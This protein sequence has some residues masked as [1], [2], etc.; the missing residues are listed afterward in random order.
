MNYLLFREALLPFRVISL[1]DIRKQFPDFDSRRLVEWQKK[2]YITRIT[3]KWYV[4]NETPRDELLLYRI[5]NCISYPSYVS[6]ETAMSYYGMIPEA[7]FSFQG[8]TTQ[9]TKTCETTVGT[10]IFKHVKHSLYFGYTIL[11]FDNIPVMI[12]DKEKALIDFCYLHPEIRTEND[13]EELRLNQDRLS[14]I[15]WDKMYMYLAV[16]N[17]KA[18]NKRIQ[19][20]KE[21][22]HADT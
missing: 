2:G 11:H 9:K 17:N 7:V 12:A 6:L 15:D 1:S 20:L 19:T 10:F 13:F 5:S 18:L 14:D 3:N 4:F 22:I 16:I 8:I 21:R